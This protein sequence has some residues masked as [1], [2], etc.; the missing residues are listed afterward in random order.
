MRQFGDRRRPGT[1][2]ATGGY[3]MA[4]EVWAL[5]VPT[6]VYEDARLEAAAACTGGRFAYL[7]R[8]EDEQALSAKRV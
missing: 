6:R 3:G 2:G 5:V 1:S 7:L 4:K 8:A